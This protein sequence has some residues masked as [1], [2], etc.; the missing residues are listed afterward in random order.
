MATGLG[1]VHVG[2]DHQIHS[3]PETGSRI[4]AGCVV[5][6]FPD[7]YQEGTVFMAVV[8]GGYLGLVRV[9]DRQLN[10]AA[11]FDRK[12]LKECGDPGTAAERILKGARFPT[13]S[14]FRDALWHGTPSLTRRTLPISGPRLFLVGDATGYIEPFTGEGIAWA[15]ESA[16]GLAPL[17]RKGIDRWDQEL[18]R[19]WSSVHRHLFENRQSLCRKLAIL[20]RHPMLALAA[21]E[22][23]SRVPKLA[24]LLIRRIYSTAPAAL[25]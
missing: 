11:A 1:D 25:S 9:E 17:V 14:A 16:Q 22:V 8:K 18:Q 21:L 6:S 10:L 23:V 12:F 15:L 2:G 7:Y 5:D 13:A 20:L 19:S 3:V 4:G 24:D